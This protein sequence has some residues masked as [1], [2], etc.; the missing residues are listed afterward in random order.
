MIA[1]AARGD[2]PVDIG[3]DEARDA[4]VRELSDPIYRAAEPSWLRRA[5]EWVGERLE[6]LFTA[7]AD[8]APGGAA[9]LVV[10]LVLLLGIAVIVRLRAGKLARSA[11]A[12]RS[13]LGE[14]SMSAAE[15]RD[16]AESALAAG[17]VA[18]AIV[19]R[20]RAI[21]RELEQRG[22]LDEQSGRTADEVAMQAGA[23]LPGCAGGLRDAS[24]V[25]DDVYYGDRPATT[26]GYQALVEVDAAVRSERQ[27][28]SGAAR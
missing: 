16:A 13:V 14:R 18:M 22:V 1:G 10:L 15:H 3:R 7:T 17:D 9:G 28:S 21:V 25:F 11:R 2:V 24:R 5:I 4:A 23:A 19:E 26:A 27:A 20:F 12:R 8:L 6:E